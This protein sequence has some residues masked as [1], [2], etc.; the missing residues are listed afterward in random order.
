MPINE[1]DCR[2]NTRQLQNWVF[3]V[4][5]YAAIENH[6]AVNDS[7]LVTMSSN[8]P[9]DWGGQFCLQSTG[10]CYLTAGTLPVPPGVRD[11]IH[12]QVFPGLTPSQGALDFVV[13]SWRNPSIAQYCHYRVYIGQ[14]T[15]GVGDEF[16]SAGPAVRVVPNPSSR[17][18]SILLRNPGGGT[19]S[20]AIFAAD[21]R[22][23]REFP[24]LE[25]RDG[26]QELRW[27]GRD[28][29]SEMVPGGAY[30]YRFLSNGREARGLLIRSR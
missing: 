2:D 9:D 22:L 5:F 19:G 25:L 12:V 17:E 20:L 13:Q 30:F 16:V 21:G 28:R 1:V 11:S 18:T 3:E 23:V 7:L 14:G 29:R 27:D 4:G 26:V 10:T 24:S 6:T 8:L 15:T